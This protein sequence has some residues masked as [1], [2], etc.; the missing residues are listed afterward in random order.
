MRLAG[1]ASLLRDENRQHHL[2][3]IARLLDEPGDFEA[4]V[5]PVLE[6]F[7]GLVQLLP[8]AAD[9][10]AL[11]EGLQAVLAILKG[12]Q[13]SARETPSTAIPAADRQYAL[14]TAV[15]LRRAG[16]VIARHSVTLFDRQGKSLG[17]WNPLTGPMLDTERAVYYRSAFIQRQPLPGL[18]AWLAQDLIPAAE[19]GRLFDDEA[20][21]RAWLLA[22]NDAEPNNAMGAVISTMEPSAVAADTPSPPDASNA[23]SAPALPSTPDT[24]VLRNA[25]LT[26]LR[27]L[28]TSPETPPLNGT[29]GLGWR[30]NDHLYLVGKIVARLLRKQAALAPF[31]ALIERN[32]SLYQ[33]LVDEGL[34]LPAPDKPIFNVRVRTATWETE[35]AV[36]KL[37]LSLFGSEAS[38]WPAPFTGTLIEKNGRPN[39]P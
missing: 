30:V 37:P 24:P 25:L 23:E 16:R 17:L 14:I 21:S 18:S 28:L 38:R 36:I 29:D 10:L 3:A 13:P 7:A 27:A 12:N 5:R 20:L 6:R 9:R 8:E 31:A 22:L 26:G 32:A 4:R 1:G 35:A 11:D 34:A 19:L 33:L 39:E 2:Q 15:L